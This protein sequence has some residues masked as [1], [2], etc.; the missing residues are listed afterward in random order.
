MVMEENYIPDGLG[1]LDKYLLEVWEVHDIYQLMRLYMSEILTQYTY[2]IYQ[3]I[4]D[5]SSE[6][7]A[8]IL[9][10]SLRFYQFEG[11]WRPSDL[12][13]LN[14]DLLELCDA[15]ISHLL[16]QWLYEVLYVLENNFKDKD[17]LEKFKWDLDYGEQLREADKWFAS[18]DRKSKRI[19]DLRMASYNMLM[20]DKENRRKWDGEEEV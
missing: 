5:I 16:K 13:E 15:D 10:G 7:K 20:E 12:G 17:E 4:N 6:T 1:D 3:A 11:K 18:L 2:N 8:E 9:V 19:M 14:G